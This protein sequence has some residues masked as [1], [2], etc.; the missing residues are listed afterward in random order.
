MSAFPNTQETLALLSHRK[1]VF[2]TKGL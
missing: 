2:K 1:S